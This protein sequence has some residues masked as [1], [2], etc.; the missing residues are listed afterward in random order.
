M[1]LLCTVQLLCRRSSLLFLSRFD[2]TWN[3]SPMAAEPASL[4]AKLSAATVYSIGADSTAS[5]QPQLLN[6]FEGVFVV[7]DPSRRCRASTKHQY[8]GVKRLFVVTS[9]VVS[10]FTPGHRSIDRSLD[11]TT[12]TSTRKRLNCTKKEDRKWSLSA[13]PPAP[14]SSLEKHRRTHYRVT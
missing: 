7:H 11:T 3:V 10:V 12:T 6:V 4:R 2:V 14:P 13:F 9:T 8:G 1:C 5:K